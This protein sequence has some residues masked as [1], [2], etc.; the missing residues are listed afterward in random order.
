M[1]PV[2][3][4]VLNACH[5]IKVLSTDH[6]GHPR[7]AAG[8]FGVTDGGV[9][10]GLPAAHKLGATATCSVHPPGHRRA[11]CFEAVCRRLDDRL[12]WQWEQITPPL[13]PRSGG[14]PAWYVLTL[15]HELEERRCG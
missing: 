5:L 4:T 10:I 1:R 7:W 3:G 15:D 14:D 12:S 2:S 13:L 9:V 11:L 6:A 8:P